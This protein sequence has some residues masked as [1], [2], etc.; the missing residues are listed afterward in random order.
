[1]SRFLVPKLTQLVPY[2][3]VAWLG[4]LGRYANLAKGHVVPMANMAA[5]YKFV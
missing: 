3:S 2:I 1:M 5:F 4:F